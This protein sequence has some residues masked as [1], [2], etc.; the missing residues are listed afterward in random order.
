LQDFMNGSHRFQVNDFEPD[1]EVGVMLRDGVH[2]VNVYYFVSIPPEL[3]KLA[4]ALK[5]DLSLNLPRGGGPVAR[6]SAL[7]GMTHLGMP[8][9]VRAG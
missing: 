4:S 8:E 2:F 1:P 6:C 5:A 3:A 9:I 7:N